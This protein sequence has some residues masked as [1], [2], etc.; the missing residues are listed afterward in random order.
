MRRGSIQQ[1]HL[2]SCPRDENGRLKPHRCHG[3]WG[4]VLEDGRRPDGTRRQISKAGFAT[5]REARAAL[6]EVLARQAAGLAD[7]QNLT[8]AE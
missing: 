5:K 1:R 7:V 8:V 4:F 3:S 2:R 6:D